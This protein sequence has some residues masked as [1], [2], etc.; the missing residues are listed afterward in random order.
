VTELKVGIIDADLLYRSQHRFPNLACMKLSGF[1]KE[2]GDETELVTDYGKTGGY[3]KI[4]LSKVFTDTYVPGEILEME[5]LTYGGTGFYYDNAPPLPEEI[6][7]HMPD[8]GLYQKYVEKNMQQGKSRAYKFYTDY[9]IGFLS[10]GC[11]RRCAF[12][13]NR[14]SLKSEAASPLE[15][16][17][18]RDRK[19][20][21]FLDDNFLACR[22]WEPILDKVLETGK[23]FQFRQGLDRIDANMG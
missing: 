18:D 10:R 15:E 21:C 20:L 7:H 11:F 9:S 5:N 12:C 8:Y 23:R 6:E 16:F 14:N 22:D 17:M 4:Y 2:R 13:V 19:K 1:H 3:D